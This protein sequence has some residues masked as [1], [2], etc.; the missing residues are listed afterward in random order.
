MKFTLARLP[1]LLA[2]LFS[3]VALAASPGS[4]IRDET[5]KSQP[6][7]SASSIG[8]VSKGAAV[9]IVGREG[10]W[11]KIQSGKSQGWVRLLSVRAGSGGAAGANLGDVVGVATTKSDP[12]RVV[13]VAGVRGLSE[14]DLKKAAYNPTELAKLESYGVTQAQAKAFANQSGLKVITV[15]ELPNPQPQ[16]SNSFGGT[17]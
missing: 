5:L 12:S 7:A 10:G 3:G 2:A 13:A 16:Q 17:Y 9:D 11:V 1:V 15:A 14:E 8:S 6:S 4:L